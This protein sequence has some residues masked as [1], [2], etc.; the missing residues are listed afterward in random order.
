MDIIRKNLHKQHTKNMRH[1]NMYSLFN[2]CEFTILIDWK[3]AESSEL[4][5]KINKKGK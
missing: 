2:I 5:N 1:Y 3:S 4:E